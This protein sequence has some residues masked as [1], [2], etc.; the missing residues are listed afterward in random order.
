MRFG[1]EFFEGNDYSLELLHKRFNPNEQR[2]RDA[3]HGDALAYGRA[4]VESSELPPFAADLV[5]Y[6][7][8]AVD[9]IDQ[10][11]AAF[12]N[13]FRVDYEKVH[14]KQLPDKIKIKEEA[15]D[16]FDREQK[17]DHFDILDKINTDKFDKSAFVLKE[18][19]QRNEVLAPID[20]ALTEC[21]KLLSGCRPGKPTI[22]TQSKWFVMFFFA[23]AETVGTYTWIKPLTAVKVNGGM[24]SLLENGQMFMAFSITFGQLM[25][26][27]K[28]GEDVRQRHYWQMAWKIIVLALIGIAVSV[29]RE[30]EGRAS[31]VTDID[32]GKVA[33][34]FSVQ[35][36]FVALSVVLGYYSSYADSNY[37]EL[38]ARKQMLETQRPSVIQQINKI[39]EEMKVAETAWNEQRQERMTAQQEAYQDQRKRHID[40]AV[41]GSEMVY[42]DLEV[43]EKT[44]HSEY[45]K[46]RGTLSVLISMYSSATVEYKRH[47]NAGS[48]CPE[49]IF[50]E[51]QVP[52]RLNN[53][54]GNIS[55]F[56][57]T[58]RISVP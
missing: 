18:S 29:Y 26:A 52:N 27:E 7:N 9:Q 57:A 34:A 45:A 6:Y 49:V 51:L 22:S 37:V 16:E 32:Y 38:T 12:V 13:H 2:F 11:F 3:V 41:K 58:Q 24:R 47:Y 30:S 19:V 50:P 17:Q 23:L 4:R 35:A 48:D 15:A 14:G 42:G 46:M 1:L 43:L 33:I 31:G 53:H 25:I 54:V 36:T 10:E 8:R 21:T 39:H 40:N 56:V 55:D 5:V 44:F 28:A 20:A